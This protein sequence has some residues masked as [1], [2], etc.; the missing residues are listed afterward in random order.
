MPYRDRLSLTV[1]HRYAK[2]C[3]KNVTAVDLTD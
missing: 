2:N 3:K 1:V